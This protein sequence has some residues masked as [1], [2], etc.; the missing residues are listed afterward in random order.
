MGYFANRDTNTCTCGKTAC[1]NKVK[2]SS[3]IRYDIYIVIKNQM[4]TMIIIF[5]IVEMKENQKLLQQNDSSSG[6]TSESFNDPFRIGQRVKNELV[7]DSLCDSFNL[8]AL[9]H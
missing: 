5:S 9:D 2:V 7:G 8:T 1:Y 3:Y 6:L 4:T